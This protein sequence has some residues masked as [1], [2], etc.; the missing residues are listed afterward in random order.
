MS[1][2][3]LIISIVT[4]III[5]G[6]VGLYYF[7][8]VEEEMWVVPPPTTNP[9]I[10]TVE[11]STGAIVESTGSWDYLFKNDCLGIWIRKWATYLP[12]DWI[13]FFW[14]T[15]SVNKL[16]YKVSEITTKAL[17][18][19]IR[20]CWMNYRFL[21]TRY[22]KSWLW[23]GGSS[24]IQK[25]DIKIHAFQ[26]GLQISTVLKNKLIVA[27]QKWNSAIFYESTADVD[28]M[29]V[30]QLSMDRY[31]VAILPYIDDIG[32]SYCN[33]IQSN[34]FVLEKDLDT[35]IKNKKIA[36]EWFVPAPINEGMEES[37]VVMSSKYPWCNEFDIQLWG[38]IWAACDVW[39]NISWEYWE[40]YFWWNNQPSWKSDSKWYWEIDDRWPCSLWYHI[41]I[42]SDWDTIYN[43]TLSDAIWIWEGWGSWA[44]DSILKLSHGQYWHSDAGGG[45]IPNTDTYYDQR[46]SISWN[47]IRCVKDKYFE[48]T[49]SISLSPSQVFDILTKIDEN[50]KKQE[51]MEKYTKS[52]LVQ[53]DYKAEHVSWETHIIND[54]II[55]NKKGIKKEIPWVVT[56]TDVQNYNKCINWGKGDLDTCTIHGFEGF[57]SFSPSGNYLLYKR[58]QLY[59]KELYFW[60]KDA[61]LVD[62]NNGNEVLSISGDLY[63][64]NW[65]L[66]RKQ[67]IYWVDEGEY[68]QWYWL[69]ITLKDEFPKNIMVSNDFVLWR[70]I[71]NT[72]LYVKVNT[73]EWYF[74]KIYD[75]STLKEVYSQKIK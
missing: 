47:Y 60:W 33:Q 68:G 38:Q 40:R 29:I 58:S 59:N 37:W 52:I 41:P 35:F 9:V 57:I 36:K 23:L 2:K 21:C 12:G 44:Y 45:G 27:I 20:L 42:W 15:S 1:K 28:N 56:S 48:W 26:P 3:Y 17:D 30:S 4:L 73:N 8:G 19:D 53:G 49:W 10:Q 55:L 62:T 14:D 69:Y 70:Y 6:W 61:V 43:V 63:F 34:D 11:T 7:L 18:D 65:S 32:P 31:L 25:W 75:L 67:F 50:T 74:L 46:D 22:G 5:A 24:F 39:S 66:D 72:L 51:D 13:T 64:S 16:Q 54:K 71:D